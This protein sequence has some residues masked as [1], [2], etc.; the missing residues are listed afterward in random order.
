M[1]AVNLIPASVQVAQARRRHGRVWATAV[2]ACLFIMCVPLVLNWM[3]SARV[4][5][6]SDQTTVVQNELAVA[7]AALR[8]LTAQVQEATLHRER[9]RALHA[10]RSWSALLA[11]ISESLPEKCWLGSLATEPAAPSPGGRGPRNTP[12]VAGKTPPGAITSEPAT[13]LIEGP[14]ALRISGF[15]GDPS[16]PLA[17]ITNLK[18]TGLFRVVNLE[19]FRRESGFSDLFFRFDVLCEW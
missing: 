4:E 17:F 6:M 5:A 14:R 19:G 9:A 8:S 2:V 12:T 10:K 18:E 16:E 11:I 13:V 1:I 3:E 7:R 15:A